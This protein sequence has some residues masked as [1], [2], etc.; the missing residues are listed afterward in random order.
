MALAAT[1]KLAP[2]FTAHEL[3]A[4]KPTATDSVVIN[5]RRVAGWLQV[6]RDTVLNK[7]AVVVTSGY[8]EP[9]RNK[10][11]GGSATTDHDDGLAADFEVVGLSGFEVYRLLIAAQ[12]ERKLPAFDQLIFYAA[13]NHV[14]VGLGARMRGQILLKTT[15]G[16]YVQ[17]AGAFVSRIRGYL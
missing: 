16:T 6:V 11:V 13:D 12:N 2:N 14:H 9:G 15:E 7:R 4:D 8:R 10:E 3:G 5:L 17:L 1:V